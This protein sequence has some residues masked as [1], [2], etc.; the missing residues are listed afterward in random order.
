M[1]PKTLGMAFMYSI[2]DTVE[3]NPHART[4][5]LGGSLEPFAPG[6]TG[7]GARDILGRDAAVAAGDPLAVDSDGL[8]A[9]GA[10]AEWATGRAFCR[11]WK[12]HELS[13]ERE[14]RESLGAHSSL[15]SKV[16][17]EQRAILLVV[18]GAM[19][20]SHEPVLMHCFSSTSLKGPTSIGSGY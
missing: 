6:S 13:L 8:D 5:T 9:V 12:N 19:A 2:D 16:P 4:V 18:V 14:A 3:G 1:T 15:S 7:W 20:T 10:T 17:R 11:E